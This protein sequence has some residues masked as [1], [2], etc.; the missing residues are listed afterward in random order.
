MTEVLIVSG[1]DG[2]GDAVLDVLAACA[3]ACAAEA[4]ARLAGH[5]HDQPV[6]VMRRELEA[7]LRIAFFVFLHGRRRPP[8]IVDRQKRGRSVVDA[9]TLR[10]LADRIVCGT[11]YSLGELGQ[12]AAS[13]HG[14]TVIGYAEELQVV[15][16]VDYAAEFREAVL[17]ATRE[18][19]AGATAAV[20]AEATRRAYG[21][22]AKE[23]RGRRG[24]TSSQIYATV[25]GWNA[26]AIGLLGDGA[27]RL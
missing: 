23:W 15:V 12:R 27:R 7:K 11:C 3:T 10:L 18:L 19:L 4:G 16:D 17:T 21:R 26:E 8:G 20:A 5:L 22:L 24:D 9:R 14:A 2:A 1:R 6:D 25:A 13:E